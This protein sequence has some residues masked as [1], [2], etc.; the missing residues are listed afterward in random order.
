MQS[1]AIGWLR[2]PEGKSVKNRFHID[3]RVA[4]G[5]LWEM[6]SWERLIRGKVAKLVARGTAVVRGV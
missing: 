1:R 6:A 2:V 4:G 3:I 5:G